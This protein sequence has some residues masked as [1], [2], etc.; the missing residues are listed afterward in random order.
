MAFK[1]PSWRLNWIIRW[2]HHFDL[3]PTAAAAVG[4]RIF[5][6]E[7]LI[8]RTLFLSNRQA[9][10]KQAPEEADGNSRLHLRRWPVLEVAGTFKGDR[11]AFTA[12]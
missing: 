10:I 4:R 6:D 3:F 7:I 2:C 1:A 5:I 9:P 11:G 12:S 8:R